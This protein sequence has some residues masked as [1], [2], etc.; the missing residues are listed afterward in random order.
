MIRSVTLTGQASAERDAGSPGEVA[1]H[2]GEPG[3]AA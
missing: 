3:S 2:E 1:A